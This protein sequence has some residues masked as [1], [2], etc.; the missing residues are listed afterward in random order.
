MDK[1][2]KLLAYLWVGIWTIGTIIVFFLEIY[3]CVKF[4]PEFI[5]LGIGK[6]A[7]FSFWGLILIGLIAVIG[8]STL[9]II[10][11]FTE[12]DNSCDY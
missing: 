5:S 7:V 8:Y 4:Y 12:D 1:L 10:L 9:Q 2:T 6:M 11:S 3:V